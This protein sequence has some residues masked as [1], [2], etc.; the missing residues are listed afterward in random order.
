MSEIFGEKAEQ[1]I[2]SWIREELQVLVQP[3]EPD[4]GLTVKE[5]ATILRASEWSV[6]RMV[7]RGEL[8]KI[9]VGEKAWGIRIAR[10]DVQAF[11]R[12]R[13]A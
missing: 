2:R 3:Q 10:R 13:A 12:R 4:E 1:E 7:K 5:V 9:P 11:L 8:P 6:Y